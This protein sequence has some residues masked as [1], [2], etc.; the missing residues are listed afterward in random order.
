MFEE[1]VCIRDESVRCGETAYMI[2]CQSILQ[3]RN[4]ISPLS[5]IDVESTFKITIVHV[6]GPLFRDSAID[7]E[8]GCSKERCHQGCAHDMRMIFIVVKFPQS[9]D[10]VLSDVVSISQVLTIEMFSCWLEWFICRNGWSLVNRK[11]NFFNEVES[12]DASI[13]VVAVSI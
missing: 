5:P 10:I 13:F 4:S 7:N 9:V 2:G 3:Y 11:A 8:A 12:S 1:F 6:D